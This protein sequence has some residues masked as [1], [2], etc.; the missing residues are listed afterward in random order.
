MATAPTKV[1]SRP[2]ARVMFVGLR[3]LLAT[4]CITLLLNLYNQNDMHHIQNDRQN[5]LESYRQIESEFMRRSSQLEENCQI[6]GTAAYEKSEYEW[7]WSSY[8]L[9]M[10]LDNVSRAKH[11]ICVPLKI[12]SISWIDLSEKLRQQNIKTAVNATLMTVRHPLARLVSMYIDKFL[13]GA[14]FSSY[15]NHSLYEFSWDYRWRKYWMPAL[16]TN[17]R[18][19]PPTTYF[20]GI[21]K[22][23][24]GLLT[25]IRNGITSDVGETENNLVTTILSSFGSDNVKLLGTHF[26]NASI[27]FEEF[28]NQVIWSYENSVADHHWIPFSLDCNVC[29]EKYDYIIHL[30]NSRTEV[31]YLLNKLGYNISIFENTHHAKPVNQYNTYKD[32]FRL[33][34]KQKL[35]RIYE[36]YKLD[37]YLFG[38]KY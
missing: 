5:E 24:D 10:F 31:P 18:I 22:A 34:P 36:I 28:V 38:F 16:I 25:N 1:A 7:S 11:R 14:P 19:S 12:G 8:L 21:R 13:D 29:A 15:Q 6:L 17:K 4:G 3:V 33:I 32:Y 35:E 37:F 23:R 20:E 30:E 27:S 9:F 2:V 26:S